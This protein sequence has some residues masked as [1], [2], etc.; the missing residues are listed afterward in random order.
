MW[1]LNQPCN[2]VG[3][4]CRWSLEN[5]EFLGNWRG[6]QDILDLLEV[7]LAVLVPMLVYILFYSPHHFSHHYSSIF[8]TVCF[9]FYFEER[10]IKDQSIRSTFDF[11]FI[12]FFIEE[13][14]WLIVI[15]DFYEPC[16]LVDQ[17]GIFEDFSVD[18]QHLPVTGV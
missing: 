18:S 5:Q 6:R 17:S 3:R 11:F 12:I 4:C 9:T 1:S 13:I 7:T 10:D 2:L 16:I 8:K 15:R 14:A